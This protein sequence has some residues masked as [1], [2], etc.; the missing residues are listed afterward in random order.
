[1]HI[2]YVFI[3]LIIDEIIPQ[4]CEKYAKNNLFLTGKLNKILTKRHFGKKQQRSI[5]RRYNAGRPLRNRM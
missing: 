1:M 3:Y 2:T 4:H 5:R